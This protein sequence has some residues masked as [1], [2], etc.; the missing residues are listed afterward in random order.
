MERDG[1]NIHNRIFKFVRDSGAPW[2]EAL[3]RAFDAGLTKNTYP[4]RFSIVHVDGGNVTVEATMVS[5]DPDHPYADRLATIEALQPRRKTF[6]VQPFG[7]VQIVP[8]GLGCEFGGYAGDACPATNLLASAVDFVVTHPNAVN[9][10]DLNEMAANVL[11]V[12]GKSLDD[13]LLGHLALLPV[14]SNRIGTIV[15]RKGIDSI[16]YVI[17]TLNAARAVK[18]I[19][20]GLYTILREELGVQI[21]W[22]RAGCAVGTLRNPQAILEAIECL[23]KQGIQ[24]VGECRSLTV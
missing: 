16:D 12:E 2:L 11:Y 22:S 9:A 18:G 23:L 20:C 14:V 21:E 5:Y 4:L 10:S 3:G 24:A 19:D 1:M 13:F 7:I 8:T 17:N 6:Q 15:D